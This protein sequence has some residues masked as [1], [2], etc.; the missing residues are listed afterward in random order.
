[1]TKY[2]L[3]I[4]DVYRVRGVSLIKFTYFDSCLVD[5]LSLIK[6]KS[7]FLFQ[8]FILIFQLIFDFQ[9]LSRLI[10]QMAVLIFKM[11]Q[12]SQYGSFPRDSFS[13]G[14]SAILK[15][16]TGLMAE[17]DRKGVISEEAASTII[18]TVAQTVMLSY[19]KSIYSNQGNIRTSRSSP[20]THQYNLK[21]NI[22]DRS[23]GVH[24]RKVW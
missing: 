23:R 17:R 5:I 4:F 6:K 8:C 9:T 14:W 11:R 13:R 16:R 21:K 18:R 22:T 12:H 24:S 20:K 15:A 7:T 3:P 1:M 2:L 10:S 19:N